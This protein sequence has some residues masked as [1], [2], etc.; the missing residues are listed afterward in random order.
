MLKL[1]TAKT[2]E[3]VEPL[4][5]ATLDE[6]ARVGAQRMIAAAP[7][8]E[9]AEY[10]ARYRD[11]RDAAGHALVVAMGGGAPPGDGGGWGPSPSWPAGERPAGGEGPAA[12]FTARFCRPMCGAR[13]GWKRVGPALPGCRQGVSRGHSA[14]GP[15]AAGLSPEAILRLTRRVDR[16]VRRSAGGTVGRDYISGADGLPCHSPRDERLCAL[17][18]IGVRPDG[19]KEV[20]AL[21]DGFRRAPRA[22]GPC[23][24]I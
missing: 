15:E 9:V 10:L 17:V 12:E 24:G 11:E 7:E 4:V 6:L 21:E 16:R 18:L 19:A 1:I 8:I 3:G 20:V 22:G 2:D 14:L 5:G 13:R 23:C